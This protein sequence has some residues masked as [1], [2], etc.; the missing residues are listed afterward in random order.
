MAGHAGNFR[1]IGKGKKIAK[2]T[3]QKE[4]EIYNNP[5]ELREII[6]VVEPT[7]ED[8][9]EVSDLGDNVIIMENLFYGLKEQSLVVLDIKLGKNT[10]SRSQ[11]LESTEKSLLSAFFKEM[12]MNIYDRYTKSSARGWRAI[13]VNNRNRAK[14]GRNSEAFLREQLNRIKVSKSTI[15]KSIISQLNLIKSTLRQSHKTFV[16]SSALIIID[17]QHPENARVKLIDLA[18]PLDAN[19]KLFKKYKENFDRGITALIN[20]FL[21]FMAEQG[22]ATKQDNWNEV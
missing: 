12:T 3:N 18:H 19:N 14:I 16:A 7:I 20:F 15:L 8:Y 2:K 5:G 22:Q 9:T 17:I 13:P 1:M 6:P 21:A 10:T 4:Y 11:L